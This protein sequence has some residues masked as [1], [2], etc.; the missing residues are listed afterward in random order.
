MNIQKNPSLKEQAYFAIREAIINRGIQKGQIYSEQW[1]ADSFQISRTPVREALL[2]LRTEGLIEVRP[3]RGVLVKN[4]TEA[5]ARSV[6]QVRASIE[7]FCSGFLA[8]HYQDQ[9]GKAALDRI[10][11][12]IERCRQSFNRED[13]LF[14]HEETIRFSGNPLFAEQF[15]NMRTKI[16]IFWSDAIGAENR[17]DEVY[18]EHMAVVQAMRRGDCVGAYRAS[19]RHSEITLCRILE[20][21]PDADPSAPFS[22]TSVLGERSFQKTEKTCNPFLNS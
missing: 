6:F 16:E 7:G 19:A 4:L 20:R 11:E 3:N 22:V 9:D 10:E 21:M 13:E 2:Q 12:A 8:L 17:W 15:E 18:Q 14:I 5:D 1:F